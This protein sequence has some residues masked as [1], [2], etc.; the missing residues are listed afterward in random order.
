MGDRNKL[1]VWLQGYDYRSSMQH[2][3]HIYSHAD[4]NPDA[5]VHTDSDAKARP[6]SDTEVV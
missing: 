2:R 1:S 3:R 6:N 4:T 5:K